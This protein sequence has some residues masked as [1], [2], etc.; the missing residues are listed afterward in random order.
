MLAA[1]QFAG[2]DCRNV[3]Q[4]TLKQLESVTNGVSARNQDVAS[5]V[6][7]VLQLYILSNQIAIEMRN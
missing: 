3:L 1:N 2:D 7:R 4:L 5:L 6:R